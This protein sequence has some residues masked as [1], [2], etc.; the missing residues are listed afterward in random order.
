MAFYAFNGD[1]S[2]QSRLLRTGLDN[3]RDA[4]YKLNHISS[5]MNLMTNQQIVD[6]FGVSAQTDGTPQTALQQAAGLKAELAA[7][8]AVLLTDASQTN[9]QTKLTQLLSMTG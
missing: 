4:I 3:L 1:V 6:V 7:D 2:A 8:V 5:N 9:V